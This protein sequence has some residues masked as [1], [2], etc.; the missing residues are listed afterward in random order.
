MLCDPCSV[1]PCG[2]PRAEMT[3]TQLPSNQLAGCHRCAADLHGLIASLSE[4]QHNNIGG[5]GNI[6]RKDRHW[7]AIRALGRAAL[8][9]TSLPLKTQIQQSPPV[10]ACQCRKGNAKPN[11]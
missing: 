5:A 1:Q 11:C 6:T 9:I 2:L 8:T 4:V 10:S 3:R 7:S